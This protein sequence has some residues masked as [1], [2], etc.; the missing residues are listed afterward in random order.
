MRK[1]YPNTEFF[2]VLIFLY[3]DWMQENA[4][5]QTLSIWELF[6]QCRY[7]RSLYHSFNFVNMRF[8]VEVIFFFIKF[9]RKI[10]FMESL[11][12][13][14]VIPVFTLVYLSL[15]EKFIF[16]ENNF[17]PR[18]IKRKVTTLHMAYSKMFFPRIREA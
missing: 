16:T 13:N 8:V 10:F 4:D 1:K 3:S 9:Y 5:Q 11:L 2:L 14:L 15:D 7:W 17:C 18:L 6:T 12:Q